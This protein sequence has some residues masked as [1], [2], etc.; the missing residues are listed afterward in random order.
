MKYK[1]FEDE[2][3]IVSEATSVNYI[4]G[5][6]RMDV[7]NGISGEELLNRLR[8]RIEALYIS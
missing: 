7:I 2:P 5:N 3:G 1:I 8:P 6:R 4:S